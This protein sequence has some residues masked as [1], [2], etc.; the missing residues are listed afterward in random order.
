M[1]ELWKDVEGYEGLYTVSNTGKVKNRF[2]RILKG[3]YDEDGYHRVCLVKNKEEIYYQVHRIEK[4]AF[5][6]RDPDPLKKFINHIDEN[7]R[8][9]DLDNLEW[10][11]QE[12]NNQYGNRGRN[13]G[14][15][16][17]TKVRCIETGE[18]FDSI[19]EAE[20]KYNIKRCLYKCFNGQRKTCAGYHWEYA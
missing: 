18:I 9:N 3:N 7:P 4:I 12:Y 2:G 20:R 10:C 19:A 15:T 17:G 16:L 1:K 14:K 5:D 6:G 13:T 8:N 11:T